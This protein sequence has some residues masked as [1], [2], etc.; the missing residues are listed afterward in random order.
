MQ[1]WGPCIDLFCGAGGLSCGFA[2]AGFNIRVG[3]DVDASA[4]LTFE[5]NHP[6]ALAIK[7]DVTRLTGEK[8]VTAHLSKDVDLAHPGMPPN[9]AGHFFPMCGKRAVM[10]RQTAGQD[11]TT[12]PLRLPRTA[13]RRDCIRITGR[14]R[15][16]RRTYCSW[17]RKRMRTGLSRLRCWKRPCRHGSGDSKDAK[18]SARGKSRIRPLRRMP[19]FMPGRIIIRS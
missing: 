5:R 8:T 13:V 4:L 18:K 9:H 6:Q 12:L 3:I 2:Q 17:F 7:E 19:V 1:L 14:C 11:G 10:I 15:Q 16:T